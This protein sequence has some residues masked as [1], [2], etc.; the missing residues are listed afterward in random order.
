MPENNL[1]PARPR[2][3]RFRMRR[4][5]L[6]LLLAAPL[7]AVAG[8]PLRPAL[9]QAAPAAGVI[10]DITVEGVFR[11]EPATVRAYI[12]LSPGDAFS[13]AEMN[14]SLKALFATGLFA[15]VKLE[16][17]G[18]RL[19]V[20]VVENPVINQVAFE[21]NLRVTDEDLAAETR[22]KARMAYT[23]AA[24][25]RDMENILALYNSRG[26]FAATVTPQIIQREQ[27]RVDLVFEISE[28]PETGVNR[29]SFIGNRF[30]SDAA[31][32]DVVTTRET[33]WFRP[34]SN[35]DKYD[36]DRLQFDQE[37]LR[38]Y[39][40]AN[41][42]ADFQVTSAVA[43]LADDRS[44]FFITFTLR[45]GPRYR[46]GALDVVSDVA[47]IR[48]EDLRRLVTVKPGAWYNADAV[49][50]IANAIDEALAEQ[51]YAFAQVQPRIRLDGAD[52]TIGVSFGISEGPKV[53]VQRIDIL[54]NVR[55]VDKVIR[56]ELL[57]AEGD[58]YN[59]AR[60]ARSRQRVQN[61][62]FFQSVRVVTR[63][64]D[65]PDS[66]IV[67]VAV[68]EQPT[69]ELNIGAGYSTTD[70]VL[71]EVSIR[72]RNLMGLGRD[73]RL[74]V[75]AAQSRNSLDM[76]L[77]EPR[78]MGKNLSLGGDLFRTTSDKQTYSSYDSSQTGGRL[79][80]GYRLNE[81]WTQQASYQF[82]RE[83]VENIDEGASRYIKDQAGTQTLS[84][85]GQTL[86]YDRRN[87]SIDPT[88]GYMASLSNRFAGP[89]G[90]VSYLQS[91]LTASY[92]LPFTEDVYLVT[93]GSAGYINGLGDATRVNDR[94][95]VGGDNLRGFEYAGIGPRDVGTDDALG[96]NRYATA[97]LELRFPVGLPNE[98]GMTGTLFANA[99][100]LSE[101]DESGADILDTGSIRN[102]IGVGLNW[103]SPVGPFRIS[104]A[105][106]VRKE[107]FDKDQ[108]FNISIGTRF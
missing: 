81:Y 35:V 47:E 22:L 66:V 37:S 92:Y 1:Q 107:D 62:G 33:R 8:M 65:S 21:G 30:F 84:V 24:A 27:N 100:Y 32:R 56:R 94:F 64:G 106:A 50:S 3:F 103:R 18:N 93:A 39:Y 95:F 79:R 72:E 42:F 60:L 73:L 16:R 40:I 23:P 89:G 48:T 101:I 96:G 20:R 6:I 90:T 51:G 85:L 68:Q 57:V 67:E 108:L 28:G 105:Q 25:Q 83:T 13:P 15:D 11:V 19:V 102:A 7:L 59:P 104:L 9:A 45:E 31:L 70:G 34:F 91:E 53:Y 99:G 41:G 17:D 55:T 88:S 75:R 44:G 98:F 52:L 80:V 63:Q 61:L 78:F 74:A 54:G 29:I 69:G 76:S 58:A 10:S 4:A 87:S 49:D 36:P 71:G 26:R 46:F 97:L 43:E 12:T 82:S 38:R 77:T 86:T 14:R 2:P 5:A